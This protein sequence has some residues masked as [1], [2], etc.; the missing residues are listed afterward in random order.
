M[1]ETLA[2][3]TGQ[4]SH[5]RSVSIIRGTMVATDLAKTRKMAEGLLGMEGVMVAP[6][7]LLLR[8]VGHRPGEPKHGTPY[9]VLDVRQ[10]DEVEVPQEM[11]NHWGVELTSQAAVDKAYEICAEKADEF[12]LGRVQKPRF[13]N[14]S[15]AMY[16]VDRDSNWWEMEYRTPDLVYAALRVKGDQVGD[17]EE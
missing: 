13:R 11:L 14:N 8:E 7:R 9:W 3:K 5:V 15:Y 1:S 16:F 10:V 12:E 6:D 2:K 4:Q 17:E